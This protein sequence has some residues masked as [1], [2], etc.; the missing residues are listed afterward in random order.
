MVLNRLALTF[1]VPEATL[2]ERVQTLRNAN[3][4]P[5]AVRAAAVEILEP[6]RAVPEKWELELLEL[7][8]L[9][10]ELFD[11]VRAALA[12]EVF[13]SPRCRA[14]YETCLRLSD[15]GIPPTFER[16]SNAVEHPRLQSLLVA[17][18]EQGQAKLP[19]KVRRPSRRACAR[20]W[21]VSAG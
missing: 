14:L 21:P 17:L 12:P 10:A 20:R 7:V 3:R 13:Q 6:R 5:E 8:L 2:R 19:T 4:R 18:D 9:T 11:E 15:A 16:L 1:R